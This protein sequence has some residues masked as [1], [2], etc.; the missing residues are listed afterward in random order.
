MNL[1]FTIC[2]RVPVRT[3]FDAHPDGG[4]VAMAMTPDAKFLATLSRGESQVSMTGAKTS[5]VGITSYITVIVWCSM[6]SLVV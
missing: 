6:C 5:Q 4:V 2:C 3:M 1:P